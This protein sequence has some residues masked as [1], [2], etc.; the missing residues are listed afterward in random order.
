MKNQRESVVQLP[1][2]IV[3]RR[4]AEED[5]KVLRRAPVSPLDRYQQSIARCADWKIQEMPVMTLP[6]GL[7]DFLSLEL[8][9]RGNALIEE[10][11]QLN[12]GFVGVFMSEVVALTVAD[13]ELHD[14]R[15]RVL[16]WTEEAIAEVVYR[17]R[18]QIQ[19]SPYDAY[20][21]LSDAFLG[22][23]DTRIAHGE[24][25]M[26]QRVWGSVIDC[27]AYL[28]IEACFIKTGYATLKFDDSPAHRASL[29]GPITKNQGEVHAF[30]GVQN[31]FGVE[32]AAY[33]KAVVLA[34]L[35]KVLRSDRFAESRGDLRARLNTYLGDL[36]EAWPRLC[37]SARSW[38]YIFS[39][40][41]TGCSAAFRFI[42]SQGVGT[43]YVSDSEESLRRGLET[44]FFR[45]AFNIGLDGALSVISHPWLTLDRALD[46]SDAL[47]VS[48][49]LLEQ[50]H[51]KA[52]EDYLKI[53]HLAPA[54]SD[55]ES[56]LDATTLEPD[57][58][59]AGEMATYAAWLDEVRGVEGER[60]QPS[61]E[62][63]D[64]NE[65]T[66]IAM[67]A[68]PQIRQSRFFKVLRACGVEVVRGKGSEKK[69]LRAGAHPFRLGSHY[70][71]NPTIPSFLA[72]QI[73]RRL[74]ISRSEWVAAVNDI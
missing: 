23:I 2:K 7:T 53:R 50:V 26:Y 54:G 40:P 65:A 30:S 72:C 59:D 11:R 34:P 22:D 62:S 20:M 16:K 29:I 71:P 47:S 18:R 25:R 21:H 67:H 28:M 57:Q 35:A 56:D 24:D 37:G 55:S 42:A 48:V 51:E 8:R 12:N 33:L 74:E 60:G 61:S 31:L 73:L 17:Y 5:A 6:R 15:E 49:W 39:I 68:L 41:G 32:P 27:M 14:L 45:G 66:Q 10:T 36:L 9:D 3:A 63:W 52:V 13:F 38:R 69:L 58:I 1:T 70:G 43:I 46:E 44:N 64:A 19:R 4:M